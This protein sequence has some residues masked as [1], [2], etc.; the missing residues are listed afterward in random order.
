[1]EPTAG[2]GELPSTGTAVGRLWARPSSPGSSVKT[3]PEHVKRLR[4]L[5]SKIKLKKLVIMVPGTHALL[6]L[7]VKS[8]CR[9]TRLPRAK[10]AAE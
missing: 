6:G 8:C 1:M 5:L 4:E 2:T 9:R 7:Q 10:R 3:K